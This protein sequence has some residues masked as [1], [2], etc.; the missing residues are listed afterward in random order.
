MNILGKRIRLGVKNGNAQ[1]VKEKTE[2]ALHQRINPEIIIEK[3]LI[4]PLEEIGRSF[5]TGE[6]FIPEVLR[7]SR[8]MQAGFYILKPVLCPDYQYSKGLIAIGTVEG[9]IHNIGKNLVAMMLESAGYTVI[10][11][12]ADVTV[13]HFIDAVNK[14]KPD[15]LA[16]SSLLTTTMGAQREVINKLI[17]MN[18]REQVKVIIGGGPVTSD[19]AKAIRADGY[20]NDFIESIHLVDRL[21]EDK[22]IEKP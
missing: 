19:Y 6:N 12:G 3:G 5:R 17:E 11:L 7:A 21:M 1:L 4:K 14:Y 10:D 8:A 20:A 16:L 13:E 2:Y 22:R 18:L 9:D 15:I